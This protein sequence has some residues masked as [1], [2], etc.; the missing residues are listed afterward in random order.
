MIWDS[1]DVGV[2]YRDLRERVL[3]LVDGLS[4]ERWETQT[5]HCPDWTV[6]QTLAHLAGVIDDGI[7]NNMVG[8]TTSAWTAAQVDKRATVT[9]PEIA[10]EWATWAPFVEARAT[11][12]GMELS[13]LVF[14]AATHEHD[15]RHALGVPGA[16][17]S[18]AVAVGIGFLALRLEGRPDG[19]P[20]RLIVDGV[21]VVS[22]DD[23]LPVLRTSAF[24]A[25]RSFGSRRTK[26]QIAALAW[27]AEPGDVMDTVIPFGYPSVTIIE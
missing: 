11:E 4:P 13:Q 18:S 21:E 9:G 8:V 16:R 15:L 12:R 3:A 27:N 26:L 23:G 22:G 2:A 19:S 25:M 10:T 24:D 6:R 17:E 20:V 1:L 7:N 14:D 5:P